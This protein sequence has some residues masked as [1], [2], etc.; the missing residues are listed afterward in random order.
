MHITYNLGDM[1]GTTVQDNKAAYT[2]A[3]LNKL[4]EYSNAS[5]ATITIDFYIT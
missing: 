1:S 4:T 3:N 5:F 2:F